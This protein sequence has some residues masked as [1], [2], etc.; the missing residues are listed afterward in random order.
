M[1]KQ[2]PKENR[3]QINQRIR[4]IRKSIGLTQQEAAE[5][6]GMKYDTFA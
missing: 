5:K 1:A 4:Q 6:L 2:K 3:P